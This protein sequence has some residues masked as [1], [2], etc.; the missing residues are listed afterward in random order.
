[1]AAAC[2]A[3]SRASNRPTRSEE[4]WIPRPESDRLPVILPF[5]I[6]DDDPAFAGE[7]EFAPTL[8]E[9]LSDQRLVVSEAVDAGGIEK[10]DA[11]VECAM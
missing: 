5:A 2:V 3:P 8:G 4:L 7:N 6:V 9:H 11:E 10:R 1:M